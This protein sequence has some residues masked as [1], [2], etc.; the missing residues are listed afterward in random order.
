MGK[1]LERALAETRELLSVTRRDLGEVE[2]T[3]DEA[4]AEAKRVGSRLQTSEEQ[5]L[6]SKRELDLLKAERSVWQVA[7][8]GIQE[9][10]A[11]VTL[12]NL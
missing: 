5:L 3:R 9:E 10:L 2:A 7:R 11:K 8:S 6:R 1:R 12:F 4:L